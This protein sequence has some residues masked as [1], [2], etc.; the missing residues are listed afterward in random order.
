VVER[1]LPRHADQRLDEAG[2]R[3]ALLLEQLLDALSLEE[4]RVRF[5][6]YRAQAA[7]LR[8]ASG[9]PLRRCAVAVRSALGPGD[10]LADVAD[11]VAVDALR[12]SLD[13]VLRVLN[14]R[15]ALRGRRGSHDVA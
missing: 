10:G 12:E 13:E 15:A 11:Q 5:L 1:E 2:L 3:A 9:E 14:R 7:L 8:D 4:H 6:P